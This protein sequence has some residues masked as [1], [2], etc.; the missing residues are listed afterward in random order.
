MIDPSIEICP[1]CLQ[2]VR[3]RLTV[4]AHLDTAGSLCPMS[5]QPAIHDVSEVAA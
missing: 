2:H 4:F 1:V 5:A 3:V